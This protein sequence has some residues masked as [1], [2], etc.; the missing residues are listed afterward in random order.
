MSNMFAKMRLFV[1]SKWPGKKAVLP[2]VPQMIR[3]APKPVAKPV[4]TTFLRFSINEQVMFAKRLSF[5][6][7]A[8]VSLHEG[9]SMIRNQTKSKRKR[10]IF[11]TIISD[12]SA[13]QFL[14][15]SLEKY[16]HLFGEFTVNIIRV[17]ENAGV[18]SDNL[19]YLADELA[20]KQALQR[21]VRSA[22]VYPIFITFVTLGVTGML[23]VFIFPKIM[24]IFKSL[25]I[26][27]PLTTRMLI[28]ISEYLQEW[29]LVTIVAVIIFM[30][31]FAL[32][33]NAFRIIRR[34][35]DW[36][37]LRL[38][39]IGMMMRA[40]NA[41]NFCRTLGLNIK[42]GVLLTDAMV[43][44]ADVT[45]N[46]LYKEAYQD[47]SAHLL[48]GETISSR[49]TKYS[50]I[51]PAML[52]NMILIGETTG[53]LSQTLMYLSD[54]YEA[55]VDESTKNLSNSI[56]PILLVMMGSIVGLIA[57]S[58]ITPIYEVTKT[59]SEQ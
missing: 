2:V 16:K 31:L 10:A 4:S 45:K 15:K 37:L 1:V 5:L 35:T 42:A 54:H 19:M 26:T 40:Y 39:V 44:T 34:S 12:L 3:V 9:V 43:I 17:G 50:D 30:I 46:I 36:V 13:G 32:A 38:P 41:A 33:R 7:K 24:P 49:M 23:T 48:K 18:L 58:V 21:K 29:G 22:L 8:G 14:S 25:D 55:E 11:D 57:V 53:N 6:V 28:A 51:F 59:L 20:K 27:L 47:I 52:P 56:E